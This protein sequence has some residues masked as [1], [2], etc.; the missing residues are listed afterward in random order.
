ME[1]MTSKQRVRTALEHK[2][3]DRVPFDIGSTASSFT[4]RTFLKV[5]EAFGIKSEDINM[6]PDQSASFYND[7][8]LE[9]VGSDFRH[10]FLMPPDNVDFEPD[11][12]GIITSE[13]GVK[14]RLVDGLVQDIGSPLVDAEDLSDLHKYPWPDPF[15][16]GRIRGLKERVDK[17]VDAPYAL[18]CRA[19]SHGFFELSWEL[20]SMEKFFVDLYVDEGFACSLLDKALEIQIN[21]YTVLL[22][23][24]GHM[25]DVVQTADDY[26]TQ[27]GLMMS[28][29][30]FRKFIKPRR[31]KLNRH[32]K[33]LA[34]K[35]KIFHH[36]CGS[37]YEIIDDLIDCGVDILNPC[38]PL[39]KDMDSYRLKKEFGDRICF[40]G[41]IDEQDALPGSLERLEKE[42]RT[43]IEAFAPGGGYIL[44]ATSNIQD[45][46]PLEN[47][48]FYID[49]AKNIGSYS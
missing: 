47:I 27:N 42:I 29:E 11:E 45:D 2:E 34:P 33:N 18:A 5:K 26:G 9:A 25:V 19:V 43:R 30:M 48:L 8:V 3:P 28:K 10:F 22:G 40:H 13:W 14:K 38:Q 36:T 1:T 21:L 12:K 20:R 46:T 23:E 4:N 37:V 6:R 17:L 7:D 39:A 31:E 32:I 15:D 16:P 24:C 49:A 41:G 44:A 35:A